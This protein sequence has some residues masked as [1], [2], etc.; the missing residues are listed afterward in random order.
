M[1]RGVVSVV[2]FGCAAILLPISA[3]PAPF[4]RTVPYPKAAAARKDRQKLQGTWYTVSISYSGLTAAR[5][6]RT[7]TITYDGDRYVHRENGRVWQAGT[8]AIVDATASPKRI[9][10]VCTEGD[11]KGLHFQSIYTLGDEDHQICSDN[12]DGKRPK[13][14]SGNG[15]F[16]RVTK[17][18][19]D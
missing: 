6:D 9:E 13:Q 17:R 12:A 19:R 7:D 16:L 8:F 4:A 2:L 14:F 18:Q 10:Y 15:S 5:Q 1:R 11:H 3:A